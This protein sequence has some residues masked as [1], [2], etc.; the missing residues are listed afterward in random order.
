[1]G[2]V[3]ERSTSFTL[4]VYRSASGRRGHDTEGKSRVEQ[5]KIMTTAFLWTAALG[6]T[7][8]GSAEHTD[9]LSDWTSLV[10]AAAVVMTLVWAIQCEGR[11][12]M[13]AI[14]MM[15]ESRLR[16]ASRREGR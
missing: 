12:V 4:R 6:L 1:M 5:L 10:R 11:R 14:R 16:D 7:V 3:T 9:A 2:A 13:E 15:G 8:F